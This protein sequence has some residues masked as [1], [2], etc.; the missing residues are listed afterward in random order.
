MEQK[1]RELFR[2]IT[3]K[4]FIHFGEAEGLS[5]AKSRG[6]KFFTNDS[7]VIHFCDETGI[8]AISLLDFLYHIAMKRIVTLDEMMELI[9]DIGDKDCTI[10]KNKSFILDEYT[11]TSFEAP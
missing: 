11:E 5:I 7:K 4:S 1:E 2:E 6:A 3:R 8:S 9:R 10:I